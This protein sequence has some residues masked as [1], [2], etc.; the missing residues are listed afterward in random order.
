MR[1]IKK[2]VS[3]I[4]SFKLVEIT[5]EDSG[6]VTHMGWPDSQPSVIAGSKGTESIVLISEISIENKN[7]Q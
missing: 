2:T 7:I 4:N 6:W 3:I 5:C 1:N